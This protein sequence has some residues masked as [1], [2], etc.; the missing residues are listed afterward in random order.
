MGLH[1]DSVA[2]WAGGGGWESGIIADAP[3]GCA[4]L[5]LRDAPGFEDGA[6]PSYVNAKGRPLYEESTTWNGTNSKPTAE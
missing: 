3:C 5:V 1:P 2:R 6:E 4:W